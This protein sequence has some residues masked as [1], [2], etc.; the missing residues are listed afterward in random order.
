MPM[1][2]DDSDI[3]K[4][5]NLFSTK[6]VKSETENPT[7]GELELTADIWKE[8]GRWRRAG[9]SFLYRMFSFERGL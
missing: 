7:L 2:A 5:N 6:R 3:E 1:Q 4:L 9:Y 8:E